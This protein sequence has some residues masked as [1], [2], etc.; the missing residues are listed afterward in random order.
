VPLGNYAQPAEVARFGNFTELS[1]EAA[2]DI[3]NAKRAVIPDCGHIPHL[4]FPAAFL[5]ELL[6]FLQ[7]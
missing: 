4:E 3:P 2:R 5:A 6:P 7:Q 1:A